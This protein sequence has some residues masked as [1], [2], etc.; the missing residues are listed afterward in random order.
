MR[1]WIKKNILLAVLLLVGL[2]TQMTQVSASEIDQMPDLESGR[3]GTLSITL[4]YKD[5]DNQK[6]S[7]QGAAVSVLKVADLSVTDGGT[8]VYTLTSDFAASGVEFDGMTASE[9]NQAAEVLKNIAETKQLIA[10]SRAGETDSSG[11]VSFTELEPAMYLIMQ[12]GHASAI[13]AYTE[14]EA[15]LVSVPMGEKENDQASWNYTV[16]SVP[17]MELESKPTLGSIQVTKRVG[18]YRDHQI[19]LIDAIDEVFYFGIFEDVQGTVRYE[20][21]PIQKARLKN[22]S[23]GTAE[24]RNL[25]EG[26]YYIFETDKDGNVIPPNTRIEDSV[27]PYT[28]MIEGKET[29]AVVIDPDNGV[30]KGEI[31]FNNVY[32]DLPWGYGIE[33]QITIKKN[34]RKDGKPVKVEDTFYAGIF[35]KEGDTFVLYHIVELKQ[36]GS[37]TIPVVFE[38]SEIA[39]TT[40]WIFETDCQG[41][42]IDPSS[43][44]YKVSGEKSVVLT[45]E[46]LE[47]TV[48]LTNE[49]KT[50]VNNGTSHPSQI[51]TGDDTSIAPYLI[52][53]GAAL[54]VVIAL[55][56]G[57]RKLRK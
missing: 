2:F 21:Y 22:S 14:M 46:E 13:P 35:T 31:T 37:V 18:I 11:C 29:N 54:L 51:K 43:F 56:V 1:N 10:G 15:Y 30:L 44:G 25:P 20:N 47:Q 49:V 52:L 32:D 55:V 33:G 8:P 34:V 27:P 45:L 39:P 16:D 23:V 24:F 17:K 5:S 26:T 40:Y 28:C 53:A 38:N 6:I 12:T 41:N 9:S 42:R 57:R 19:A 36:N 4:F 50:Q 48:E 3:K 7:I